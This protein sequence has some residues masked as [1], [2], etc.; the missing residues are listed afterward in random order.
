M[1]DPITIIHAAIAM[2]RVTG[3]YKEVGDLIHGN[4]N[5]REMMLAEE[6]LRVAN[7]II[8]I[9]AGVTGK[10]SPPD[11]IRLL[12]VEEKLQEK[13][14]LQV[15]EQHSELLLLREMAKKK[16]KEKKTAI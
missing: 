7:R 4:E 8:D 15:L 6:N 16:I 12:E 5:S 2:L 11:I 13:L 3:I 1:I 9:A 14:K 10:S